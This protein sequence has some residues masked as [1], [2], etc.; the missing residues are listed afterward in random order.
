VGECF[1]WY[2]LTWVVPD[3]IHRV[4]KWLCV[5]V[6]RTIIPTRKRIWQ[7]FTAEPVSLHNAAKN[8]IVDKYV[9]PSCFINAQD[10]Q[11][12]TDFTKSCLS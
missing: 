12:I 10:V 1:F 2:Q 5:C 4:V 6:S 9:K 7:V 8:M 3:K 11:E